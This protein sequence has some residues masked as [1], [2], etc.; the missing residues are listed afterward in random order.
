MRTCQ[1]A[2][3][4]AVVTA[5]ILIPAQAWSGGFDIP[6]N[7]TRAMGRGG[8]FAA[9]ADEP[10]AIYF[11]PAALSQIDGVAVTANANLW[12]YSS[13]FQRDPFTTEL[14]GGEVTYPFTQTEEQSGVF[15]APS[16]FVSYDFGL[17][18]WG[19][20]IGAYGPGSIG[21]R[22]FGSPDM[23]ALADIPITDE[24]PRNWGHSYLMESSNMLLVFPSLAVAYDFGPVQLGLTL[25]LAVL[26]VE[27]INASDGGG[28]FNPLEDS[29]EAPSLYARTVLDVMDVRPTAIFAVQVQPIEPLTLALT[30]RPR[31]KF[32]ADGTVD[33]VFPVSIADQVELT[34]NTAHL[35]LWLPDVARFGVRWAFLS[36]GFE[37]GDIELDIV[38]EGW[39]R[40]QSFDVTMDGDL[41]VLGQ[42]RSLP[43]I[44]ILKGFDN[45]LSLRL[46]GSFRP[47]EPFVIRAGG[48]Y[49]GAANSHFFEQGTTRPGYTNIDFTPFQRFALSV[50]AGYT[51][52]DWSFDVA[53]MHVFMPT[54]QETNGQVDITYPLWVCYD[55]QT[56]F[57]QQA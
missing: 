42:Q 8:A 14:I 50:G 6:D 33:V 55:P 41:I 36:G 51:I 18:N 37:R 53:Y 31:I 2:A 21:R 7:G 22:A 24:S 30:Y 54:V 16:L 15:A 25:Q 56:E 47:I 11:N 17:E 57:D 29:I 9:A 3:V 39:S 4:A 13:T 19:F 48:Y 23:N 32:Q 38:Y 28:V 27:F 35:E 10:S 44:Q 34:D 49:E 52:G 1:I 43:P 12:F 40:M 45:T 5:A 20:G 26:K 46:G